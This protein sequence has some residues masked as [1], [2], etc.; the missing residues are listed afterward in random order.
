MKKHTAL[1]TSTLLYVIIYNKS[2][3]MAIFDKRFAYLSDVLENDQDRTLF[4]TTKNLLMEVLE[5]LKF[6]IS[7][8]IGV[9]DSGRVIAEWH[10]YNDF[11][12][13]SIIPFSPDKILFEGLKKNNTIF[14]ITTTI[15]NLKKNN[16]D[17]L[18]LE[19]NNKHAI[20]A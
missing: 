11:A 17:E 3:R 4:E 10:D 13:I 20:S 14:T 9:D 6:D 12:A 8:D 18:F 7:P 16:N 15:Q 2:N 5:T 1:F 19:L